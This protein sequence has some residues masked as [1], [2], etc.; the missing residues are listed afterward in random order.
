MTTHF[1][2]CSVI[3]MNISYKLL[4]PADISDALIDELSAAEV[5]CFGDKNAWSAASVAEFSKNAYSRIMTAHDD[6]TLVGYAFASVLLDE[7][8]LAN[9]A[10]I[11]RARRFGIA[12][13]MLTKLIESLRNAGAETLHLEVREG[14]LPA[15][16]LYDSFG[17]EIDCKRKGYYLHP[18]EDAVLMTLKLI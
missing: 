8:E 3:D 12:K 11:P 6:K 17:F 5:E 18:R 15:R 1:P 10:V 2:V 9:I 7:A 14:N 13:A 16:S 4:S